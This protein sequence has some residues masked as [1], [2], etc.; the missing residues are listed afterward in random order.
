MVMLV[1]MI[2]QSS[3]VD[4]CDYVGGDDDVIKQ[5]IN[6]STF[7]MLAQSDNHYLFPDTRL[8]IKC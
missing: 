5:K 1:M 3:L 7:H 2:I 6:N 4:D 8:T